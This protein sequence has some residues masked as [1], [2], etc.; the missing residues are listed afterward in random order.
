MCSISSGCILSRTFVIGPIVS[1]GQT[2]RR[3]LQIGT[4][5]RY[6]DLVRMQRFRHAVHFGLQLNGPTMKFPQQI[7]GSHENAVIDVKWTSADVV[8]VVQ[9]ISIRCLHLSP[10]QGIGKLGPDRIPGETGNFQGGV[11]D[12]AGKSGARRQITDQVVEGLHGGDVGV[13]QDCQIR[14]RS[15]EFEAPVV[16][17]GVRTAVLVVFRRRGIPFHLDA[18]EMAPPPLREHFHFVISEN[19]DHPGIGV[20]SPERVQAQPEERDLGK[21]RI[22]RASAEQENPASYPCQ[23]VGE[24]PGIQTRDVGMGGHAHD[25]LVDCARIRGS[26]ERDVVLFECQEWILQLL[27]QDWSIRQ[28]GQTRGHGGTVEPKQGAE[29]RPLSDLEYSHRLHLVEGRPLRGTLQPVEMKGAGEVR[30]FPVVEPAP[31]A[32][33][34]P[35]CGNRSTR[36]A[37]RLALRAARRA[38]LR[39]PRRVWCGAGSETDGRPGEWTGLRPRR[40]RGASPCRT[41]RRS[42]GSGRSPHRA[43]RDW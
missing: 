36:R 29:T 6:S 10:D 19:G 33:P 41:G 23:H 5:E 12:H 4:D 1:H 8:P 9:G 39:R 18:V 42:R 38:R 31:G 34:A 20:H 27:E 22:G 40:C 35:E 17:P 15:D 2:P 7:R 25:P 26:G 11:G 28:E 16:S 37:L 43:R 14:V 32:N 13:T 24:L 3:Q 30:E 21:E